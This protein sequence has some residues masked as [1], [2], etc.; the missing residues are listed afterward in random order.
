MSEGSLTFRP[1]SDTELKLNPLSYQEILAQQL[2]PALR[3]GAMA[4]TGTARLARRIRFRYGQW[5]R[6]ANASVWRRPAVFSWQEWMRRLWE[7]SLLRGGKAGESTLL[8]SH[9][10]L[11]LWEQALAGD[12]VEGFDLEQN[13]DLARKSWNLAIEYG[14]NLERLRSEIEGE[15]ERRFALWVGRFEEL[16]QSGSWLEPAGLTQL[17]TQDLM[18]GAVST[19]GPLYLLGLDG[20]LPPPQTD[21]IQ[22]LRSGGVSVMD[23]PRAPRAAEVCRIEY[24]TADEELQA[25]ANWTC[26]GNAGVVL[27][28]FHERA[29]RA[30]RALLDRMQPAWQARGFPQDAPLNSAEA[31][32]L[33]HVGPAEMALDLLCLLPTAIDFEVA[34]R[35]LRGAYLR[36]SNKEAGARARLERRIRERLVGGEV[37][38]TQLMARTG[39]RVERG[40]P[41]L[42]ETLRQGWKASRTARGKGNTHSYRTWAAVFTT[43]LREM[44]WP[45]G[46]PL[47]SSEQ[48]AV[49]AWGRLLSD[50]GGFDAVSSRGVPL[51]VALSRIRTMARER[52][53]QPQGPD[54][55]VELLPIEETAGMHFERLWVAGAGATLWPRS[56]RPAPLLPLGLQRRLRMPQAS[57]QVAL[58]QA[59]RQT[60]ALLQSTDKVIFSWSKVAA[61]GVATTCSPLIAALSKQEHASVVGAEEV[62]PYAE[63][64]RASASL[65]KL[66]KDPA[67]ALD[68]SEEISGGTRLMDH[69]LKNP[70][71]AFSEFRLHAKEFPGPW[72]GISPLDR[73]DIMHKL[74]CRLYTEYGDAASL[75]AALPDLGPKLE[76]WATEI[77]K[78]EPPGAR[79]L[80]LGLLRLERERAVQ[81]A[82]D[83]VGLD[84]GRGGFRVEKLEEQAQLMLEGVAL[85]MRLDRVDAAASNSGPLVLD[86]KTGREIPLSGLNPKRL[87]SSQL[88]AYALVTE[89]VSGVAY[90]FLSGQQLTVRGICDPD[91]EIPG[92][93]KMPKLLPISRHRDFK[94]YLTWQELLGGWRRALQDAADALCRGDARIE[95]FSY[96]DGARNQYQVLSRIQELEQA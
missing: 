38:R 82:L 34:S 42:A 53:F 80:V 14:L 32:S 60:A 24:E 92:K 2:F 93:Q 90:V 16:C 85:R 20:P 55:A 58:E 76:E 54:Q 96:E 47:V 49:E 51:Q 30:R 77:P 61:E 87:R 65:E 13:A 44:G 28:D 7:E 72:D 88:P 4:I 70:F 26:E 86:Y 15:D 39:A 17:L 41:I 11:M 35:V 63:V 37:T 48:Q 94:Q 81:L 8:S 33:A 12:A 67:P 73:G 57:P 36:G 3:D 74:L 45:G 46:R 56:I 19:T 59:R 40:A 68:E 75:H 27:L 89:G 25:A 83:W 66:H 50:F 23:P 52:K 1:G 84:L 78:N 21:L 5:R 43:F 10:S 95:I 22:V 6:E 9:G 71:R 31:Q 62:T 64:L 69:Q 79:P 29:P 91:S 18:A